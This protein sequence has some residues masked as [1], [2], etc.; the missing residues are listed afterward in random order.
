MQCY[1]NLQAIITQVNKTWIITC[2]EGESSALKA[3]SNWKLEPQFPNEPWC[4]SFVFHTNTFKVKTEGQRMQDRVVVPVS[5]CLYSGRFNQVT[6]FKMGW[7]ICVQKHIAI[8]W[9]KKDKLHQFFLT[10]E[11]ISRKFR[12]TE[13]RC[14]DLTTSSG[15]TPAAVSPIVFNLSQ[16]KTGLKR[17]GGWKYFSGECNMVP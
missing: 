3:H 7:S 10:Y 9:K 14:A 16:S 17:T 2:S 4:G 6:F 5:V 11:S 1:S 15:A 12:K 13:L 8:T